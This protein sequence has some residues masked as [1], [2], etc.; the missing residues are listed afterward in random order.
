M[1]ELYSLV[2]QIATDKEY[3]ILDML[4]S[5]RSYKEISQVLK[6]SI[7]SIRKWFDNLLD[8]KV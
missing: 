4:L 6:C 3:F 7:E 8:N 2:D 5:G 1:N